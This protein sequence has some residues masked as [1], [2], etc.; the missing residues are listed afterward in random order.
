MRFTAI[1]PAV[2]RLLAILRK[3]HARCGEL[4]A[5]PAGCR[6][7]F[8]DDSPLEEGRFELSVPAQ[9]GPPEGQ[10]RGRALPLRFPM[11]AKC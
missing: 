7:G 4:H 2:T 11:R 10:T 1:T 3:L 8:V 5:A 9:G 6:L